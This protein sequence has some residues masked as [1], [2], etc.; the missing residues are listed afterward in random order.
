MKDKNSI[1]LTRWSGNPLLR[2]N[3]KKGYWWENRSV[4]NPGAVVRNKKIYLLYRAM[5]AMHFSQF[6][7]AVLKDPFTVEKRL[8]LPVFEP[9][10]C[11]DER[12]GVEDPRIV[13]LKGKYR[14]VYTGASV[15]SSHEEI[16]HE[17]GE[18]LIPWRIRCSLVSTRDFKNF[19]RHGVIVPEIDTKDGCLFPEKIDGKY[20]LLHRIF[21]DIWISFSKRLDRFPIGKV[22]CRARKNS[23]D[24]SR[25][26]A[27]APPV[28][29]PLGWLE[30]YHGVEAHRG[31]KPRYMV[32]ML[33]LD[34]RDPTKV[35]YRSPE[36]IF[37]PETK[38]ELKGY[39]NN[40]VFPCGI[41]EWEDKYYLYY[42]MADRRI[43]VAYVEKQKVWRF[44]MREIEK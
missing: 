28:K 15:Y 33:L 41:V 4:F 12:F 17:S 7:L 29:T 1:K 19:R 5:G 25:I 3:R 16:K 6:G 13:F 22:L 36:P 21:P 24:N 11:E 14:I 9:G 10:P 32:G 39:V 2:P 37:E 20:V 8:D 38:E 27:G 44:L 43:G 30:F 23:W 34:L 18:G 35:L 31:S 40:V 26:G 42:G